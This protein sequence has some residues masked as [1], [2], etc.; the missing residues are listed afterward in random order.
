MQLPVR[1]LAIVPLRRGVLVQAFDTQPQRA[2]ALPGTKVLRG[3]L[4]VAPAPSFAIGFALGSAAAAGTLGCLAEPD[5][6][7]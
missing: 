6:T 1:R 5:L 2:G 3:G 4:F 7:Y